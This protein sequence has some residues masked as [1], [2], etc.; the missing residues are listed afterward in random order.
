VLP[1]IR[2]TN[3]TRAPSRRTADPG[4]DRALVTGV[5]KDERE[6]AA[7]AATRHSPRDEVRVFSTIDGDAPAD[8]IRQDAP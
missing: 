2:A 5:C 6:A 4:I 8:G 1:F 3:A 7:G